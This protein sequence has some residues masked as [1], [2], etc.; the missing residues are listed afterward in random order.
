MNSAFKFES[1]KIDTLVFEIKRIYGLLEFSGVFDPTAW[2]LNISVREPIF[3]QSQ[4]KYIGGV[5][6]GLYLFPPDVQ[7]E[8]KNEALIR[9]DI[10]IAGIFSAVEEGGFDKETLERLVKVQI[11]AILFPYVRATIT[12]LFA[13]AGFGSVILPL[14]NMTELARQA[15]GEVV[16]KTIE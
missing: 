9:L 5:D 2:K 11:P 13:N 3:V 12:S 10:G 15:V 6:T 14:I 1:Y 8:D 4:K 7:T 16:I